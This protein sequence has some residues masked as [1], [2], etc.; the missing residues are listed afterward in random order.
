MILL[1]FGVTSCAAE[2]GNLTKVNV[3]INGKKKILYQSNENVVLKGSKITLTNKNNNQF[4]VFYTTKDKNPNSRL[5]VNNEIIV[6]IPKDKTVKDIEKKYNITFVKYINK[7]MGLALF[8]S[9]LKNLVS[10]VNNLNKN[11]IKAQFNFVR[12]W[13]LY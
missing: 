8:K 13:E 9:D 2:N 12:K 5:I 7:K 4:L 10:N 1:I 11:G 6:F 3:Y